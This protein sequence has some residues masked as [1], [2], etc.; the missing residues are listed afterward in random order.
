MCIRDSSSSLH[1]YIPHAYWAYPITH[2]G[3]A[4]GYFVADSTSETLGVTNLGNTTNRIDDLKLRMVDDDRTAG[5]SGIFAYG[6][7]DRVP[8]AKG[9]ELAA[10]YFG[11]NIQWYLYQGYNP[12]LDFSSEMSIMFWV[13]DWNAQESL[14]HRG[15]DTT[16]NSTTSFYMYCD[17]GNDIRFTMTSNGSTEQNFEIQMP[18]DATGWNHVC[19]TKLNNSIK[20]YLNGVHMVNGTSSGN[21]FS[22]SSNKNGLYIGRGPVGNHFTGYMALLKLSSTAPTESEVAKV[23][24]AE[25]AMFGENAKCTLHGTSDDV[26][27]IGYD[28]ETE[29]LHIG[30]DSGR[31][32]FSGLVRINNTDVPVTTAISAS[33]GL[34]AEQ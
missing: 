8:V 2:T 10:Y 7:I 24:A 1:F 30:T 28:S 34:I 32:D 27:A 4:F 6:E 11:A 31:S 15:P 18:R 9:A 19:F 13:K 22:Q 3:Y 20:G 29:I 23:Y 14:L 25:R 12:Y 17:S 21:I 16:R 26:N 33:S 5:H